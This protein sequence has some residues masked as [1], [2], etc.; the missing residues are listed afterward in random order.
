[1]KRFFTLRTRQH[2]YLVHKWSNK[3]E[4]LQHSL[5][6]NK[7][8]NAERDEHDSYKWIDPEYT[9][10]VLI[11]W[12]YEMKRQGKVF[13][14]PEE[15]KE[16]MHEATFHHI[17]NHRH[18]PEFWDDKVTADSLNKCDR[19]TPSAG[20]KVDGT[21]MPLTYVASMVGD[22]LAMSEELRTC[23]YD[24]IK[25][26]VGIRWDFTPNTVEFIYR[27]VEAVWPYKPKV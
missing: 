11:T 25:K 13:E 15:I 9:P 3:I 20:R 5:I 7:L 4:S 10:Y 21:N 22:W 14:L 1:M 6:D 26:N 23:P 2:L 24:W 12:N 19:D 27:L 18:H 17:K 16:A 8:L